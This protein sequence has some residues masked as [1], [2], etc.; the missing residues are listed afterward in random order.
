VSASRKPANLIPVDIGR[1]GVW[2]SG[3]WRVEGD[4]SVEVP[5][6]LEGLGY[7]ALWSSGGY[8]PELST[9]FDR[10]LAATD[11]MV[12]LSGIVSIWHTPPEDLARAVAD[13]DRRYPSR[14]VLGLGASHD[15]IVADYRNPYARMVDY[16]DELDAA[17]PTV[18]KEQRVLAALGP[19]MMKLAAER[20]AG[21]HPY[22]VP[23]EHTARARELLGPDALLAPEVTVVLD[24]NAA[25]ARQRARA[26]AEGYLALPNYSNNLRSLGFN[27]DDVAGGGSDR[28]L[29][30]V[31]AWG[32]PDDVARLVRQHFDAGADHVCVQVL[33]T[34]TLEFFPLAEYRTL[35]SALVG[36]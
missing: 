7:T 19:R 14:F 8:G 30:A 32:D 10:L 29:D 23:V 31:V 22:F 16:L 33:A 13:L 6:E 18:A 27:E 2:W 1:V 17:R 26:F 35:A 11:R 24:K 28:L 36:L 4:A 20:S 25:M 12:V 34:P 15:V 3:S 9:R 21:A 5:A